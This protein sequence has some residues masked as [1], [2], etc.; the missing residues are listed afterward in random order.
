MNHFLLPYKCKW[1]GVVLIFMGLVEL[2]FYLWF[3]FRITIPVF[4]VFSSFLE[5]KMFTSFRTNIADELI[6]LTL[7]AGFFMAAFSRE[8]TESEI[9][10]K[11]RAKA[12]SKAV[13]TN[14]IVLIFSILFIYGNGFFA[15]LLLN[16]FSI[17][18]FYLIFFFLIKR[19]ELR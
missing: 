3:D 15:I 16:L 2:V 19:K 17:F 14:V 18:I 4:A 5:T 11:L 10:D 1:I 13:L 8:K 7:L 9:L 6:M 12:F